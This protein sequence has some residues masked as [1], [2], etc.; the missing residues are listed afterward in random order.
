MRG[1]ARTPEG[2]PTRGGVRAAQSD[3]FDPRSHDEGWTIRGPAYL[4]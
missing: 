1:A 2:L 3:A 4:W